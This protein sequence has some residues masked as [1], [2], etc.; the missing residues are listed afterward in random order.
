MG[1]CRIRGSA[2]GRDGVGNHPVAGEGWNAEL[3]DPEIGPFHILGA[4]VTGKRKTG[5]GIHFDRFCCPGSTT[6]DDVTS[7]R[8]FNPFGS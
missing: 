2:R 7:H 6:K 4:V 5:C 8:L 1:E 3:T